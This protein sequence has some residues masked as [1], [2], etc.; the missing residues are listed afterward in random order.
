MTLKNF[1]E[2][3]MELDTKMEYLLH[4]HHTLILLKYM[5]PWLLPPKMRLKLLKLKGLMC[6]ITRASLIRPNLPWLK[7]LRH[8]PKDLNLDMPTCTLNTILLSILHNHL[9]MHN[10]IA[11]IC[12]TLTLRHKRLLGSLHN[13]NTKG[14]SHTLENHFP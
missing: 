9:T 13:H 2:I 14:M 6:K 10:A 4:H 8:K 1:I 12:L 3:L 7:G 5:I 11:N